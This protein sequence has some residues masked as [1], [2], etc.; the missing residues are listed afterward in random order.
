MSIR[1]SE[2]SVDDLVDTIPAF[3]YEMKHVQRCELVAM[4]LG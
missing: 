1:D 4:D 3:P 2:Y